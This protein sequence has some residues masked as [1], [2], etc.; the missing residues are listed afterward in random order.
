MLKGLTL[1]QFLCGT[2]FRLYGMALRRK[3][4]ENSEVKGGYQD[5]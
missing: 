2:N 5:Y 1:F 4:C 3:F